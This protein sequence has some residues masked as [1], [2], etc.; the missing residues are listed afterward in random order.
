[1]K[2]HLFLTLKTE[3]TS[4]NADRQD[5]AATDGVQCETEEGCQIQES[6]TEAARGYPS[7]ST[8][9]TRRDWKHP[10]VLKG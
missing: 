8:G 3:V 10:E 1:M 7:C 5:D 9:Q 6:K 4:L 2:P